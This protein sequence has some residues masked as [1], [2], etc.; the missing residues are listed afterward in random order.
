MARPRK[1]Q[2]VTIE[3]AERALDI[4]AWIMSWSKNAHLGVPLWRK[5]EEGLAELRDNEEVIAAA[6]ERFRQ[7]KH[8]TEAR[9]S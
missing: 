7:S 4:L 9:S 5:L 8:Q 3:R 1:K 6:R 2:P